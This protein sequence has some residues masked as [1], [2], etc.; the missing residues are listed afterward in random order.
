MNVFDFNE[1]HEPR[2]DDETERLAYEVIGAAIEVHRQM[3]PGLSEHLYRRCMERELTLKAIAFRV[4]VPVP[5]F[6]KGE[7]VG[8][9]RIDLLIGEKLVVE[10]KAVESLSQVHRSQTLTYLKLT[11]L[12]L[13]LLINFN[14]EILKDGIRR[15]IN[16]S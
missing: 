6:Y 8:E 2:A 7:S 11:K 1:R 9:T 3:G 10:L 14:V 12:Q 13:G 15:V 16:R 4:E 5:V